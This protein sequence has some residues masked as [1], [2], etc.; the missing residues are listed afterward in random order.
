MLYL[1]NNELEVFLPLKCYERVS[2]E[3]VWVILWSQFTTSLDFALLCWGFDSHAASFWIMVCSD[4]LWSLESASGH[5][6]LGIFKFIQFNLW[7]CTIDHISFIIF[8]FC[9]IGNNALLCHLIFTQVQ[10]NS[11]SKGS[12]L[13]HSAGVIN[14]S[15][16]NENEP[17]LKSSHYTKK[18]KWIIDLNVKG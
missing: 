11:A 2:E 16:S 12:L 14:P 8:Y 9:K 18:R 17:W 3:F 10:S 13:T 15:I 7:V 5:V 6:F 4:S 1:Y